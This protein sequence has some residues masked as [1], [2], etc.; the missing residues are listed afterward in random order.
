MRRPAAGPGDAAVAASKATS[1]AA[2]SLTGSGHQ[3]SIL[4]P[5]LMGGPDGFAGA[6][7][8]GLGNLGPLLRKQVAELGTALEQRAI[9]DFN[10]WL[11]RRAS[12]FLGMLFDFLEQFQ[13]GEYRG[14]VVD[15][16]EDYRSFYV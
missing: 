6:K 7:G 2:G 13:D 16:H 10:D 11:V 3:N 15:G 9:S 4:S 12:R 1:V 14:C 8:G 5:S